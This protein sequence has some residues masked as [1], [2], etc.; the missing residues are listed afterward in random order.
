MPPPKKSRNDRHGI[1]E[2][3]AKSNET[4]LDTIPTSRVKRYTKAVKRS[5]PGIDP[6][7]VDFNELP[8][9]KPT[10]Q[11]IRKSSRIK[12]RQTAAT[13]RS[14][15]NAMRQKGKQVVGQAACDVER[16]KSATHSPQDTGGKI[17]H[18]TP[19]SSPRPVPPVIRGSPF[20]K[21]DD[22]IVSP[23][24]HMILHWTFTT[25]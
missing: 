23:Q 19:I 7:G 9:F 24:S 16:K 20:P 1:V 22:Q 17:S 25:P 3:K 12:K 18:D 14:R 21:I 6:T 13:S 4:S 2:D 15:A 11:G 10:C 8:E 5:S